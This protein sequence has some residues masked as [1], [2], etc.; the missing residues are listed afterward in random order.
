MNV[1]NH[2]LLRDNPEL[3]DQLLNRSMADSS[4][5]QKAQHYAQLDTQIQSGADAQVQQEYAQLREQLLT[6]L[7]KP[8]AAA[9]SC[10][11]GC[12]GTGH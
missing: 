9:S 8:A 4:F 3:A 7:K 5:A 2:P 12:G 11:G 1:E 10:C 6:V